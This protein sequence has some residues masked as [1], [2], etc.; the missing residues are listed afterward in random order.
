M[1][2]PIAALGDK[3][4]RE[5]IFK[6]IAGRINVSMCN[7]QSWGQDVYGVAKFIKIISISCIHFIVQMIFPA[8]LILFSIKKKIKSIF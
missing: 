5:T 8:K 7:V 1:A 4:R 2:G 6:I 3:L